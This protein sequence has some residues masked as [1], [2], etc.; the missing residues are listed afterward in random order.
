MLSQEHETNHSLSQQCVVDTAQ[1]SPHRQ[2]IREDTG[3][4]YSVR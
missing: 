3:P 1:S 4:I 2:A